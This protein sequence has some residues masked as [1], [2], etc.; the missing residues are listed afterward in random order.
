MGQG[1]WAGMAQPVEGSLKEDHETGPVGW[2]G[3]ACGSN[4]HA[5]PMGRTG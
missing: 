2:H 1:L 5:V 3:L 4:G